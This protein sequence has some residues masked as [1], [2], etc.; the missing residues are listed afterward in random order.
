MLNI[1][2]EKI[3]KEATDRFEIA[4]DWQSQADFRFLEDTKFCNGDSYNMYQW[5]SDV[6]DYRKLDKKPML[7]LNKTRQHCLLIVNDAKQNKPGI[8]ILPNGNDATYD[9]AQMY[10]SLM[11]RIEYQ[12][13]A[14]THYDAAV[15]T[16][17]QGG[18]GYWRVLTAYVDEKS[19]NQDI[20]IKG[21]ADPLTVYL[22]PDAQEKDKS[23]MKFAIIF[24]KMNRE[25]FIKKHPKYKDV[26]NT[27]VIGEGSLWLNQNEIMMAEYFTVE[28]IED[29]LVHVEDE[30]GTQRDE[31]LSKLK[32][33]LDGSDDLLDELLDHP[34]TKT[35]KVKRKE[36]HWYF[37]VGDKIMD[38]KVWPGSTIP[39]V[40]VIGEETVID[41][42]MDRKGHTRALIDAQRMYNYWSSTAVEYGALQTKSP[43]IG[44]AKAIE[45]YE[46]IWAT[47]NTSNHSILPYNNRDD[48]GQDIPPPQRVQPPVSAP[49]A[50]EGMQASLMEMA[51]VSGQ[52]DNQI[53]A[54]GNERTGKAINER[55]RQ[56]DKATY[57][58]INAVGIAIARTGKIILELIPLVY[59]T[60]RVVMAMG[61]DKTSLEIEI[62]PTAKKAFEIKQKANEQTAKRIMN[63]KI[64]TYEV[65]A[66]I[67]P[68]Y[69]TKREEAFQ[70]LTL[71]LTQAPQLTALIGDLLLKA[72]DFPMAQEAAERLRRMVPPQALGQGPSQ[73]E[74]ML[75]QQVQ[76]MQQLLQKVGQELEIAKVKLKGKDEMR[77]IDVYNAETQRLK[78]LGAQNLDVHDR[79]MAAQQLAHDMSMDH[80]DQLWQANQADLAMMQAQGQGQ[81]QGQPQPQGQSAMP[82]LNG[83]RQAP[84]GKHY[85]PDPNRPGK[86]L[87]VEM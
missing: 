75:Q 42:V 78:V 15:T 33:H 25:E 47:A 61:E 52:Y 72:G 41:G 38:K 44:P 74:Q 82:E 11:R 17:V 35:R 36:V 30:D 32:E 18:I 49:V 21:I 39:I 62:D 66:D 6:Q 16:M 27:P 71:I 45:G 56:G 60:K 22:D 3:L 28:E 77:D 73:N 81:P 8:K 1:D 86:Y 68:A 50:M 37:I 43:W 23:D 4:R 70:A 59:D 80:M 87:R 20:F 40:A 83:V 34:L 46:Q 12:S 55:Q 65:Q 10:N 2:D 51:L 48:E 84:D 19:F 79:Q 67:G 9:A 53:G 14:T 5:P 58:Y 76:Q 57:H 24:D 29:T 7:T 85:V 54:P 31:M 13:D 63:P 26:S 69:A 64:G